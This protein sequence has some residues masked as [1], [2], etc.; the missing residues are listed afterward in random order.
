MEN[1]FLGVELIDLLLS[2][3]VPIDKKDALGR[4][5]LSIALSSRKCNLVERLLMHGADVDQKDDNGF[6]A[7]WSALSIEK[8]D[9]AKMLVEH[10]ADAYSKNDLGQSALWI[11]SSQGRIHNVKVLVEGGAN[12]HEWDEQRGWTPMFVAAFEQ[13]EEVVKY[14]LQAGADPANMCRSLT[15]VPDPG[16]PV[17]DIVTYVAQIAAT[18]NTSTSTS[19]GTRTTDMSMDVTTGPSTHTSR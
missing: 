4:P 14:L 16:D 17:Q 10:G 1:P 15:Q 3:G 5:A 2:A 6:S 19:E 18:M 11:A 9:L 12:I 7:L 13:R 8:P